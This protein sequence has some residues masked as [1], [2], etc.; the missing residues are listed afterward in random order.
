MTCIMYPDQ[1]GRNAPSE[2]GDLRVA[3]PGEHA[4]NRG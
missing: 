2:F 3:E 4:L 1:G